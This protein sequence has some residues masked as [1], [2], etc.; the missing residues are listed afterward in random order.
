MRARRRLVRAR[1]AAAGPYGVRGRVRRARGVIP[2]RLAGS[3]AHGR[4]GQAG[5]GRAA[6]AVSWGCGGGRLVDPLRRPL[7]SSRRFRQ[8]RRAP[9]RP[10]L[11]RSRTREPLVLRTTRFVKLVPVVAAVVL[12][13]GCGPFG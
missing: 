1:F 11:S 5:P 4:R 6:A 2:P 9:A 8:S 3:Q 10:R 7:V 13:G 12:A